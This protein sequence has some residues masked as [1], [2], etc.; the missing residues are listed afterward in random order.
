ML[1][2]K[3]GLLP[4]IAIN[5]IKIP[6]KHYIAKQ[7]VTLAG[8]EESHHQKAR[9]RSSKATATIL[10]FSKDRKSNWILVAQASVIPCK[11]LA[12]KVDLDHQ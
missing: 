12:A 6:S 9:Q 10:S 2:Q 1:R 4:R 7:W 5:L 11:N 8:N 3:I